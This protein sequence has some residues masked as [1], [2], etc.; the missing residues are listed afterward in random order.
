M[1]KQ[2]TAGGD[3]SLDAE[4]DWDAVLAGREPDAPRLD[5][6]ATAGPPADADPPA[7]ERAAVDP[8][9]AVDSRARDVPAP[10][11]LGAGWTVLPGPGRWGGTLRISDAA[12]ALAARRD[13]A[14]AVEPPGGSPAD[15]AGNGHQTGE[16]EPDGPPAPLRPSE[17]GL[18]D[19]D[20]PDHAPGRAAAGRERRAGPG[21]A[22][23]EPARQD[24][25]PARRP[26][27]ED[28][29]AELLVRDHRPAARSG[30][31]G[32]LYRASGR[33]VNL[34]PSA[35]ELRERALLEQV[36]MPISGCFRIAAISL[37][38]GVG[39]TTAAFCL[40]ATLASLRGDRVIAIDANPDVGTLAEHV[41]RQ[42]RNDVWDLLADP[43]SITR[44]AQVRGFTSQS[45]DRLEV[46]ASARDPQLSH[47]FDATDY[48]R[49]MAIAERFYTMVVTDCG[50]GMVHSA[51][52]GVLASVDQ[53]VLVSSAS[54]DGARSAS[55]TLDWLEAQGHGALAA[56]ACVV[57][58]SVRSRSA[59]V[60][61]DRLA[62]HFRSR[63]R[64]V[65]TVPYDSHLA[66]GTSIEL[67]SLQRS[68]RRSWVELAAEVVADLG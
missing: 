66:Q 57:V 53:L 4:L 27:A 26:S 18:P 68:T 30:L 39:K 21:R 41:L 2:Q 59:E 24:D 55:A 10:V 5:P 67:A 14:V 9:P 48:E 12:R 49:V 25:V 65:V 16:W 58:N 19:S 62:D 11:S 64:A 6:V 29:T 46:L 51:M 32:A 52:D 45:P 20:A 7:D 47:A 1:S 61:V 63:S 56:G 37:K 15:P 31:R 33:T 13:Q 36:R 34:G 54:L 42:N 43:D 40:G 35:A 22:Q 44:Y 38:G 23:A 17:S 60:D 8:V 3:G 50:T 28:L